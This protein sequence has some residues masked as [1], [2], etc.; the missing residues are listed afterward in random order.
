LL[1]LETG[2]YRIVGPS[3]ETNVA[4]NPPALP[5]QPLQPTAAET[6]NVEGEPLPPATWSMWRWLVLAAIV[7]LWLEWW[8]YYAAREKQRMAEVRE[9][10]GEQPPLPELEVQPEERVESGFRKSNLVGR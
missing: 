10:P 5:S 9:T 6:A 1:V 3:G 7:A 8:L 2:I 4:V